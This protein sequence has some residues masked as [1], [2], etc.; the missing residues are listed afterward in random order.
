MLLNLKKINRLTIKFDAKQSQM[1]IHYYLKHRIPI[2]HRQF[3]RQIAQNKE[4]IESS[5]DELSNLFQYACLQWYYYN[6]PKF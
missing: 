1:T 3:F 6:K 2:L 4:K 5:C